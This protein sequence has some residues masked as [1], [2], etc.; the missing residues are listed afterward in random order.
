[1]TYWNGLGRGLAALLFAWV[2][3]SPLAIAA[4]L[5]EFTVQLKSKGGKDVPFTI[6][7]DS[8]GG[9]FIVDSNGARSDLGTYK[10]L[11]DLERDLPTIV[12][13][14]GGEPVGADA[15]HKP[16][17]HNSANRDQFRKQAAAAGFKI[18]G[19]TPLTPSTPDIPRDGSGNT[20]PSI[21]KSVKLDSAGVGSKASTDPKNSQPAKIEV[22]GAGGKPDHSFAKSTLQAEQARLGCESAKGVQ[23]KAC[24]QI[25]REL[26]RIKTAEGDGVASVTYRDCKFISPYSGAEVSEVT[27]IEVRKAGNDPKACGGKPAKVCV[28]T[29][30]CQATYAPQ[31][32]EG[33]SGLKVSRNIPFITQ[34]SCT[35]NE[36]GNCR[37]AQECVNDQ[38]AS[39]QASAA[40]PKSTDSDILRRKLVDDG[41]AK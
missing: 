6:R 21:P 9:F 39:I 34:V 33:G 5:N 24:R 41:V 27:A 22:A 1:M 2:V 35:A 18:A 30:S 32:A 23:S 38:G 29:V 7:R 16:S 15:N 13:R 17:T 25:E 4:E 37:S 12:Q 3:V 40:V 8:D 14:V 20:D 11:S 31:K 36:T 19:R 26:D 28:G 10:K